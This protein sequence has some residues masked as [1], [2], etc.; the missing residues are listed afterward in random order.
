MAT[1]TKE[2]WA[3][4]KG[5]L[6]YVASTSSMGIVY[7]KQGKEVNQLKGYGDADYGGCVDTRRS[8]T[9]Y[10]FV[11]NGGAVSW[12]SKRQP[13][14]AASTAESEYIAAAAAVV[15]EALW[16]RKLGKDV[17]LGVGSKLGDTATGLRS[18]NS[19]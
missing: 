5:V 10:V 15:K 11:L 2:H 1:P 12:C 8:T 4:A 16:L 19:H 9:G 14:V 17:Q 3:A 18:E 7:R 6:R 13:T